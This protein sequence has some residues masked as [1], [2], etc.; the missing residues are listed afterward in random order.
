MDML[1][2]YLLRG[3]AKGGHW[4]LAPPNSSRRP[5]GRRHPRG[6]KVPGMAPSKGAIQGRPRCPGWRLLMHLGDGR[7]TCHVKS[8][9]CS[10]CSAEVAILRGPL[11]RQPLGRLTCGNFCKVVAFLLLNI[12]YS[13][14]MWVT[15][16]ARAKCNNKRCQIC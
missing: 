4:A 1:G 10:R 13:Q 12:R 11:S 7:G 16:T 6:T 5:L 3:A 9:G 8:Q 14:C 15:P 2:M